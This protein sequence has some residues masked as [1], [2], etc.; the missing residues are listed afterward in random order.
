MEK[1]NLR[2]REVDR[3]IFNFIK[4]GTKT[5]ET[6]AGTVKFRDIKAGDILVCVCGEDKL[7]KVIKKATI[8]KTIPEL[9]KHYDVKSIM[10]SLSTAEEAIKQWY[11]FPGYKEKI[12]EFGLIAFEI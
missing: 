10:P 7:E 6:R 2:F 9:L 5:V 11:S 1:I 4:N 3:N 12:E 8:F